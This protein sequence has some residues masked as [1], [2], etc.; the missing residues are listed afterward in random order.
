MYVRGVCKLANGR[1]KDRSGSVH[2]NRRGPDADA[3]WQGQQAERSDAGN[4]T[5]TTVK[6]AE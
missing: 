3:K 2:L 4:G 5:K 1:T 6:G